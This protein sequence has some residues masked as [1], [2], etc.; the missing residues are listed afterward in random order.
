MVNADTFNEFS[1]FVIQDFFQTVNL[2]SWVGSAWI[3]FFE[4]VCSFSF[5]VINESNTRNFWILFGNKE[6]S[7]EPFALAIFVYVDWDLTV[8]LI[9][10]LLSLLLLWLLIFFFVCI[11]SGRVS[12]VEKDSQVVVSV[13]S[14]KFNLGTCIIDVPSVIIEKVNIFIYWWLIISLVLDLFIQF[15]LQCILDIWECEER[16][17]GEF[18]SSRKWRSECLNHL[19]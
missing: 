6:F 4:S 13:F 12:G 1:N 16:R 17:L 2:R 7:T 18:D 9:E 5:I 8:V 15:F 11:I 14:C 19:N 3:S 10:I